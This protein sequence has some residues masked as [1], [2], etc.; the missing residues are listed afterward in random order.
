MGLPKLMGNMTVNE[1]REGL[2]KTK[3]VIV[4]IGGTEQHGYHLPL[5]A[6]SITAYEVAKRV[7]QK[8][9]C[10]V[11]PIMNYSFSG[12]ELLGTTD[13]SPQVVGLFLMDICNSFANQGFKNIIILSGH[14]GTENLAAIK[15]AP[16]LFY[17]RYHWWRGKVNIA[18]IM[19]A[20]LSKEW[21]KGFRSRDYHAGLIETSVIL[22]LRPELVRNKIA[23]D[24]I[25]I[26]KMLRKDPDSYQVQKKMVKDK[27][28]SV[29]ISQD[30]RIKVGVMGYI[31]KISAEIG[32]KVVDECV[33]SLDRL[34]KKMEPTGRKR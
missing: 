11:A 8:T 24:K 25:S 21:M 6:D 26:V 28:V 30:P 9:G 2:K 19:I 34:V 27:F 20:Y 5:S 18:P 4:P 15:D 31:D 7:S 12:G 29:Q 14:G 17:R 23:M 33:T 10:F 22:Y 13:I 3:T 1:I 32:K 16:V